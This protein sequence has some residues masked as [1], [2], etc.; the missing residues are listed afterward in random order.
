MKRKTTSVNLN[1]NLFEDPQ[2]KTF[3]KDAPLSVRMR[4]QDLKDFVGQRHILGEGKLLVRAIESDRLS[5]IILYGPPG[6]GKTT[7]AHCISHITQAHFESIN[8]VT[9]NVDELRRVLTASKHRYATAGRRT[10]LFIDEIHRFN[11]AQQD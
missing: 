5:S 10:I 4:P 7:L 11:K 8:A 1:G 2:G 6:T 9:S 3:L